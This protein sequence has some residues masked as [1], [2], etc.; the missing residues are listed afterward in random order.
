MIKGSCACGRIQYQ[1]QAKPLAVNACHCGTCQLVSGAA[2][3]AFAMVSVQ[4][5]QWTKQPDMWARSDIAERGYCKVCGASVSMS[6]HFEPDRVWVTLGTVVFAEPPL[7]R[8]SVHIFLKEKAPWF[9]LPDDGAERRDEFSPEFAK[10]IET[11]KAE[12][13]QPRRAK[14]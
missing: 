5:L 14:F 1:S 11:W 8:P 9:V 7:P 12:A 10:F 3:L 6:Y 4:E 2:F 13:K